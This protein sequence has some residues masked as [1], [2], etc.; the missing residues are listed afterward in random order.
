MVDETTSGEFCKILRMFLCD[1]QFS[2]VKALLEKVFFRKY[3][4][5]ADHADTS[6]FHVIDA[7]CRIFKGDM[8]HEP[9]FN[10]DF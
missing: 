10:A 3:K 2:E 1:G 7:R 9:I 5:F 6:T 8:L 4:V